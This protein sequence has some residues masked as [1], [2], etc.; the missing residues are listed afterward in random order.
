M[1]HLFTA[2]ILLCLIPLLSF[3]VTAQDNSSWIEVSP[4]EDFFHVSMPLQPKEEF[5]RSHYADLSVNGKSYESSAGGASYAVWSL[6][7]ANYETRQSADEYL[8]ACAELIW[9]GLLKSAFV[10]HCALRLSCTH[11]GFAPL[12]F[13]EVGN[14]WREGTVR[15]IPGVTC[16]DARPH[17]W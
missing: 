2:V 10:S 1:K 16:P 12:W 7:N 11:S 17:P 14:S 15:G 3:K 5:Q 8:D 9:E 6:V 13:H 4:S